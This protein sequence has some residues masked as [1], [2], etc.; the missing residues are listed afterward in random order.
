MSNK[1]KIYLDT[2]VISHLQAPDTPEKMADTL[3]VWEDLKAGIYD[4][5]I[6]NVTIDE[7][8]D[9]AEPKRSF[10][11]DE[12]KKISLI[13]IQAETKVEELSLE[14][15]RLGILKEKSIDDCMHIATALLAK[16]DV[17]VSWNFKH[18]VN[19]KTIEG[20]KTISKTRGFDGIKIYCPSILTGGSDEN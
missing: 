7:I 16:C 17:I 15:V 9:C 12:L 8:N 2:S 11:L 1:T 13:V 4:V 10:M 3:R 20:V 18:I 6:S 5:Y 19:D 14:F